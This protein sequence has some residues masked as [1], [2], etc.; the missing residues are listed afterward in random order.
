[1]ERTAMSR[2][3]GLLLGG[4]LMAGPALARAETPMS[5][6]EAD[7]MAQ[8]AE[9]QAAQY[10]QQGGVGYKTGLVQRAEADANRYSCMADQMQAAPSAVTSPEAQHYA[11]LAEQYKLMGGVGYKT[12]LIQRAEADQ[13]RAEE[14]AARETAAP[15][16]AA[17]IERPACNKDD[18]WMEPLDCVK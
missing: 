3:S 2:L 14:A 12:G 9:Q 1:M 17:P 18:P 7:E 8:T 11:E 15:A 13:R 10:K 5:P 4:F 6:Q 16:P